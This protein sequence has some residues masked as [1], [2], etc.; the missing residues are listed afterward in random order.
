MAHVVLRRYHIVGDIS[1]KSD[2]DMVRGVGR[3]GCT[4]GELSF[5]KE[6]KERV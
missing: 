4:V 2:G 5:S 6:R 3:R 1:E